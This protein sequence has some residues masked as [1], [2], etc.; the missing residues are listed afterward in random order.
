MAEDNDESWSNIF[1]NKVTCVG[2][3]TN[4][5][6]N[7]WP[8]C[9]SWKSLNSPSPF[10][11]MWASNGCHRNRVLVMIER[12]HIENNAYC[13]T[14]NDLQMVFC[15][16]GK[17]VLRSHLSPLFLQSY[18]SSIWFR[19]RSNCIVWGRL[20]SGS[21]ARH[22][23]PIPPSALP[24]QNAMPCYLTLH[25]VSV[26]SQHWIMAYPLHGFSS[27]TTTHILSPH[28]AHWPYHCRLRHFLL[29]IAS[30]ML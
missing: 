17:Y 1:L 30:A 4:T 13:A 9:Y 29:C 12:P 27:S 25:L 26:M 15:E 24:L 11:G 7:L 8:F 20:A 22:I 6:S 2:V 3:W 23:G 28:L 19:D 14:N 5:N 21:W 16:C 18:W 10:P